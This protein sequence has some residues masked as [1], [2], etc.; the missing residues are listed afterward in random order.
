MNFEDPLIEIDNSLGRI[1][2]MALFAGV[3]WKVL[4]A[5]AMTSADPMNPQRV[6]WELSPRLP[7]NCILTSDSGSAA[8]WFDRDLQIRRG[9]MASFS[10]TLATMGPGVPYA[11]G[12][13]FAFPDRAVIALVGD[14]A[15][16]MKGV[17]ELIAIADYWKEW[18]I[19]AL[20]SWCPESRPEP[21]NLGAVILS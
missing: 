4:E 3:R 7:D 10:G 8:S 12:A 17:Y 18:A 19:L 6:V 16:L 15:M 11:I 5:R 14:G 9:M 2:I 1:S 13:K 21:G 20:S